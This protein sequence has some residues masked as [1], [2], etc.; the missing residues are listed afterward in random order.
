MIWTSAECWG[1]EADIL[2]LNAQNY[3]QVLPCDLCAVCEHVQR[4]DRLWVHEPTFIQKPLI[5]FES[6]VNANVSTRVS[7][8]WKFLC[9]QQL[10]LK[11]TLA[12]ER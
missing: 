7:C 12:G 1:G 6:V 5:S 2:T 8:R 4:A 11:F 9:L 3:R 10:K